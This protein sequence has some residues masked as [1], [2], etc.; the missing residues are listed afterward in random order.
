MIPKVKQFYEEN[1]FPDLKYLGLKKKQDLDKIKNYIFNLISEKEIEGKEIL[2]VGCG[3][4][5]LSLKLAIGK[6]KVTGTDI[7]ETSLKYARNLFKKFKVKG[8]FLIDDIMDTKLNKKFDIVISLGVLHH[9]RDPE[10]G[11]ANLCK[12][13]K[14]NGLVIASFYPRFK[15]LVNRLKYPLELMVLHNHKDSKIHFYD[16]FKHP[17]RSAHSIGE[18]IGWFDKNNINFINAF[19][20]VDI[21]SY[22]KLF[23]KYGF[24]FIKGEGSNPSLG[25]VLISK[26]GSILGHFMIETAMLFFLYD[27]TIMMVGRKE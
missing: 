4:G 9:T 27:K 5:V 16:E 23:E 12:L 24:K 6:G 3:T 8:T 19:P 7:S 20:P 14:K 13:T 22:F 15:N 18:V 25:K 1:P 11:F 10:R 2:E 17:K 26:K 21:N